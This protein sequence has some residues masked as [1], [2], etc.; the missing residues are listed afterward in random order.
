MYHPASLFYYYYLGS[1]IKFKNWKAMTFIFVI[2]YWF[3]TMSV[4]FVLLKARNKCVHTWI[5]VDVM[6]LS[7]VGI[8]KLRGKKYINIVKRKNILNFTNTFVKSH[9]S[10]SFKIHSSFV[11]EEIMSDARIATSAHLTNIYRMYSLCANWTIMGCSSYL[12]QGSKTL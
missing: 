8:R 5:H 7:S 1:L 9:F 11:I 10:F 2:T 6:S 3:Q 12:F 4:M